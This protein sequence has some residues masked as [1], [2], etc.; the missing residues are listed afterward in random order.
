MY[1][2]VNY[3]GIKCYC[4]FFGLPFDKAYGAIAGAGAHHTVGSRGVGDLDGEDGRG[5]KVGGELAVFV[6]YA[7]RVVVVVRTA[8]VLVK[9]HFCVGNGCTIALVDY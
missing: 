8:V 9:F 1:L 3:L 7:S 6:G 5:A 2:S 4:G